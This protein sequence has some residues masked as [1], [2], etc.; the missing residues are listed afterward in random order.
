MSS[1]LKPCPFCGGLDQ[2]KNYIDGVLVRMSCHK[3]PLEFSQVED[4]DL[5]SEWN[6]RTE[7]K[8]IDVNDRLPEIDRE[9]ELF[10]V[11]GSGGISCVGF[12][13]TRSRKFLDEP[14]GMALE[15]PVTHWQPF[16][17]PPI[18]DKEQV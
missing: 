2:S 3:C 12:W 16:P 11:A 18:K 15:Y 13:N 7:P 5:I 4:E 17:T 8:W 14:F 10:L 9:W 6:T 1:E